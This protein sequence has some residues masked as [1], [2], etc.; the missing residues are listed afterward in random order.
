MIF[1]IP[2]LKVHS[3]L[4]L[5]TRHE[6]GGKRYYSHVGTGNFNEKTARLYT[7]FSLLTYDQG[8]GEDLAR[9]FDF[10]RYTYHRHRYDHLLVSPHSTR[11]GLVRMID[12]EIEHALAGQPARSQFG[13]TLPRTTAWWAQPAICLS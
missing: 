2:G 3:K 12:R 6:H 8:I 1:G 9:V 10:I 11:S 4:I 13:S 5:I 7:D